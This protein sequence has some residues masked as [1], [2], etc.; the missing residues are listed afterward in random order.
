MMFGE[1]GDRVAEFV[2]EP[3]LL[4]DLG[5][6]LRG[7]LCRITRPHQIENAVFHSPLLRF[8]L[9]LPVAAIGQGVK[10]WRG[11]GRFAMKVVGTHTSASASADA[12][13]SERIVFQALVG[14]FWLA[15]GSR[16]TL[17]GSRPS[18]TRLI[19][20]RNRRRS[21]VIPVSEVPR[22]SSACTAIGLWPSCASRSSGLRWRSLYFRVRTEPGRMSWTVSVPGRQSFFGSPSSS[23]QATM[24]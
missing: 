3:G 4:G 23:G 6:D 14:I 21:I 10:R 20:S 13:A 17:I 18:S 24:L 7:R 1:P 16:I 22:F 8:V 9:V 12:S 11:A 19:C 5:E 2:G 15:C